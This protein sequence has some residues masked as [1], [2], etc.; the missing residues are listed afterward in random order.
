MQA[1]IAKTYMF[2]YKLPNV[3]TLKGNRI[4]NGLTWGNNKSHNM[5]GWSLAGMMQTKHPTIDVSSATPSVFKFLYFNWIFKVAADG[6]CVGFTLSQWE[7]M[8]DISFVKI[9][10]N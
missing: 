1:D 2:G 9:I 6:R 3:S 8:W 7:G 5:A 10:T 4:R